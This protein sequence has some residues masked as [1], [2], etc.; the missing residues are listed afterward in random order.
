MMGNR[1]NVMMQ[2]PYSDDKADLPNGLYVMRT[3]TELKDGSRNVSIM[4]WNLTIWPIHLARG[5]VIGQVAVTNAVPEAQC[6]PELLKQLNDESKDKPEP[7]KLSMQQRQDLLLAALQKDGGL[8][9]LKEWPPELAKKAVALLLEF[10]YVFSLEPNGCTDTTKHVIELMKDEPFKERFCRI[11][12]PLV[13]EVCQHIQEMLDGGAIRPSQS[14]SCNAVVLVRKK[15]GSLWFCID[16]RRLNARTKKDTYPLPH[17]QETMES[18][19]GT[20]HFSCMDLKSGFWQVK[21][22]EESRQYTTFTVGSMGVYKFLRM[23]YALCNAPATF[24]HLM[25]NCLGELKLMYALIYL[26]NVIVYSKTEEEHLVRLCSI[27]ERF[28]QHGL[29]LKPSKCNFFHTEISYLGHKVS[30]AGMEPGTE[31][32]K[33]IGEITPPPRTPRCTSS[34]E[35]WDTS[36]I[37][38]KDMPGLPSH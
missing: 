38:S 33:G 6:S 27:L 34:W 24:Q 1:L 10:H 17:M 31:G 25:Q 15:D 5:W 2:A 12:P 16:F 7:A 3:Y 20:R 4:L 26:D 13:D 22:A 8:D 29:K 18:M 28:M 14:P 35:P 9:H 32:L 30:V 36:I 21:M 19:V 37:S 11:V 23:P